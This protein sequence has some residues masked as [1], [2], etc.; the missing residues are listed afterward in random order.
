M[1]QKYRE[2]EIGLC[3]ADPKIWRLQAIWE[4]SRPRRQQVHYES[5]EVVRFT[6]MHLTYAPIG[7]S[8]HTTVHNTHWNFSRMRPR[9]RCPASRSIVSSLSRGSNQLARSWT[10]TS[11]ASASSRQY[12]TALA[13]SA[14]RLPDDY[15]PPTQPPSARRPE[16]RNSQLLRTYTSLIRSTPLLLL[17]Q[18]NNLTA[19][20]WTALRRELSLAL[21]NVAA[22][23]GTDPAVAEEIA[24]NIKLQV[25]RTRIFDVA[26]RV[27]EYFDPASVPGPATATGQKTGKT[28]NHDL[29]KAAHAAVKSAMADP[30][31][32]ED[33]SS[34]YAQLSPLMVGPLALLT[35]PAVSPAHL[36]TALSVLAPSAPA[37][38]PPP[39]RK[40]P[41]YYE[42]EAQSALQKLML[43]GGRIEGKVFD[44]DGVRWVGGI[45]GGL[46]GLRAQLVAMLQSA[47]MGLTSTLEG[48]GKSLW[49]TMESR[50]SVLEEEA[51]GNG[52]AGEKGEAAPETKE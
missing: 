17:F 25:I 2:L 34:T 32:Q 50:R 5:L 15:V 6:S 21:S 33:P 31:V 45:S 38:P 9:L 41:G 8:T 11:T 37:F 52:A 4:L 20:E 43:V 47:G 16:S 14:L 48:T 30:M 7:F 13:S 44:T 19:N 39:K 40:N 42:P 29:S 28:Y 36:A 10:A 26:L 18:H 35:L 24:A 12:A 1:W 22:P 3:V 49:L 27:T 23:A 46:E 51:G